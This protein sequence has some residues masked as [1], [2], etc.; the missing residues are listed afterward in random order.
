M[1]LKYPKEA[2]RKFK[3]EVLRLRTRGF[4]FKEIGAEL[5]IATSFAF[6]LSLEDKEFKDDL[7]SKVRKCRDEHQ[8]YSDIARNLGIGATTVRAVLLRA[9]EEKEQEIQSAIMSRSGKKGA[10]ARWAR[11]EA[12]R[13]ESVLKMRHTQSQTLKKRRRVIE[14]EKVE[15]EK[16]PTRAIAYLRVSTEEQ[17]KKGISLDFQKALIKNWAAAKEWDLVDII[18]DPGSSGKNLK[19]PGIQQVMK[20]CREDKIDTVIIYK[21]DRLSRRIKDMV[22]VVEV[23]EKHK[24]DLSSVTESLDTSTAMGRMF[25]WMMTVIGALERERIGERVSDARSFRTEK[26]EWTGRLP[27]GYELAFDDK[28]IRIKGKLVVNPKKF[29]QYKTVKEMWETGIGVR[30]IAEKLGI[31]YGLATRLIKTD[32]K[33]LKKR[34]DPFLI[35]TKK[36]KNA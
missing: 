26:G 25:F 15:I 10:D 9:D 1:G 30:P 17:A 4:N 31:N 5:G 22:D 24:V 35:P 7:V 6:Q 33:K 32:I 27:H 28:G 8:S 36:N 34:M 20:M 2:K 16:G 21:L 11:D 14:P 19:R 29:R 18:R 12:T 13:R 3:K 23:F